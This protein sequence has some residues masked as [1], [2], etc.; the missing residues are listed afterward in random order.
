MLR[1]LLSVFLTICWAIRHPRYAASWFVTGQPFSAHDRDEY[2]NHRSVMPACIALFALVLLPLAHLAAQ[3][4]TGTAGLVLGILGLVTPP[5]ATFVALQLVKKYAV[6]W[7][8]QQSAIV[9]Q[10]IAFLI[11]ALFTWLSKITGLAFPG[12]VAGLDVGTVTA[13][14]NGVAAIGVHAVWK[15]T[16]TGAPVSTSA[17][18]TPPAAVK[19]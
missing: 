12:T 1:R 6:T 3:T 19:S 15:T 5:L 18:P 17:A 13:L 9:Q 14:L 8:D 7:I 11:A 16:T 10:L 2:G 4:T